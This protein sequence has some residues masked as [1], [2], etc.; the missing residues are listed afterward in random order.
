MK[1]RAEFTLT[2][3]IIYN[4]K[5]KKRKTL[6]C[7]KPSCPTISEETIHIKT[8]LTITLYWRMC[9]IHPQ[10]STDILLFYRKPLLFNALIMV[11]VSE[12]YRIKPIFIPQRCTMAYC[13]S[14]THEALHISMRQG[15]ASF[16]RI[17]KVYHHRIKLYC[18]F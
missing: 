10:S 8:L 6:K 7:R 9:R 1:N 11:S 13:Y 12:I 16:V 5:G 2:I 4:D 3:F 14:T 17:P 15:T 18:S